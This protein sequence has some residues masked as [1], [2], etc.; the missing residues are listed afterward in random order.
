MHLQMIFTCTYKQNASYIYI[1]LHIK[2]FLHV[3]TR[4]AV[5]IDIQTKFFLH[6]LANEML[7]TNM[8]TEAIVGRDR[9]VVGFTTTY[10]ISA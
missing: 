6:I 9:I 5:Y 4:K 3:F 2:C 1:F 10:A 7:N 8:Y